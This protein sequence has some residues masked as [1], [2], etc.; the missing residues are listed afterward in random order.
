MSWP[1]KTL[2]SQLTIAKRNSVLQTSTWA[3]K[4]FMNKNFELLTKNVGSY[5]LLELQSSNNNSSFAIIPK[6]GANLNSLRLGGQNLLWSAKN[7]KEIVDRN[8]NS[9]AG[10][11][12]FPFV[13]RIKDGQYDFNNKS[14]RFYKNEAGLG[15]ALHGLIFNKNFE[16]VL[17]DESVGIVK[18]KYEY[19]QEVDAY[20]FR[21]T[22]NN[23]FELNKDSLSIV[24]V[25]ENK[26]EKT[27]P[28]GHGW[29]PYFDIAGKTDNAL[30]Q[31]AANKY[32]LVDE[33][34]IPTGEYKSFNNFSE[35]SQ[36]GNTELDY[37]FPIETGNDLVAKLIYP[38]K[39][40]SISLI[41]EGYPYLQVYTPSDRKTIAIEPQTS[42]PDA[43]NNGIGLVLLEPNQSKTLKLKILLS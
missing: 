34:F 5:E 28:I 15:N 24:T 21:V 29:H 22:V 43:F 14:Y 25:I 35:A 20:P 12:L 33:Q 10:A 23:S 31:I 19:N 40:L 42:A 38:E 3:R 7:L 13:N 8:I 17:V 39:N 30:L 9:Y 32:F 37:C 41:T 36:I 26:G 1:S 18:L 4:F 2:R 27:I 6:L 16:L 11:Q